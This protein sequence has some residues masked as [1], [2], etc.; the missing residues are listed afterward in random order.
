MTN[1][2]EFLKMGAG[3]AALALAG[4]ATADATGGVRN[5]RAESPELQAQKRKALEALKIGR[6]HV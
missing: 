3:G 2:R 5:V 4:C 1:R 6:A